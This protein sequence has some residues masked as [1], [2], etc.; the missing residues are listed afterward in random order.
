MNHHLRALRKL[1][2]H[3]SR[4]VAESV[5]RSIVLSQLDYCNSLLHRANSGIVNRLQRLQGQVARTVECLHRRAHA[6][7]I[8]WRLHW[9]PVRQRIPYKLAVTVYT[10][11]RDGQPSY[12]AGKQTRGQ[13]AHRTRSGANET[14]LKTQRIKTKGAD[15][16]FFGAAPI[17]RNAVPQNNRACSTITSFKRH[18]KTWLEQPRFEMSLE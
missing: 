4:S 15:H 18:L 14:P 6:H 2:P 13:A 3:L 1:C 7:P 9:L 8:L 10:A 16:R 11:L 5:G 12:L 17:V